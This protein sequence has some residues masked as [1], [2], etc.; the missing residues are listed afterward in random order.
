MGGK[1]AVESKKGFGT[2]FKFVLAFALKN[3]NEKRQYRLPSE[4]FLS[5]RVLLVDSGNTNAIPLIKALN[6]FKY[7]IHNIPAFDKIECE[8][9][10]KYDIVIINLQNLNESAIEKIK[11]MQSKDGAKV[12]IL[13]QLYSTLNPKILNELVV[14]AYL[15]PPITLQNTL[16]L[17]IE[18]YH[19]PNIA[20]TRKN[21]LIEELKKYEGKKILV[22]EDDELNYKVIAGMLAKTNVETHYAE[23]GQKAVELLNENIHFDL[24]LMDINMPLMNGYETSLKI[25]QN[26]LLDNMPIVALSAD[27][28]EESKNKAKECGMQAYL[29]KPIKLNEFY[30]KIIELFENQKV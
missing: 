13:S 30:S 4:K 15:K 27:T 16:N 29:L 26:K 9:Q 12:V 28:S 3:S 6:Y 2:T 11:S 20:L 23:N 7:K 18:L 10:E 24:I 25:R 1:I 17:I 22:V 21:I 14:D 8:S 19:K 5:K